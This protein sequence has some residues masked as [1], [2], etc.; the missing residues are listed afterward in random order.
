MDLGIKRAFTL[1]FKIVEKVLIVMREVGIGIIPYPLPTIIQLILVYHWVH[2]FMVIIEEDI[3][4]IPA[5][6]LHITTVDYELSTQG[7]R[8]NL[9]QGV[10]KDKIS[11]TVIKDASYI[12]IQIIP[13]FFSI[14]K[15]SRFVLL[16][17]CWHCTT[18]GTPEC[19]DSV[20]NFELLSSQN[21]QI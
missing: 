7:S 14:I 8:N 17:G 19:V 4:L 12:Q 15:S 21:M 3:S 10:C 18:Q 20:A 16:L 1:H 11:K 5:A 6:F 9:L 2:M 13:T